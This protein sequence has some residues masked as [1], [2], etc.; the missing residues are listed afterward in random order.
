MYIYFGLKFKG[1]QA[2]LRTSIQN[3]GSWKGTFEWCYRRRVRKYRQRSPHSSSG[4][5]MSS[6]I[7]YQFFI[8]LLHQPLHDETRTNLLTLIL[9][10][11][12]G[13]ISFQPGKDVYLQESWQTI[14]FTIFLSRGPIKARAVIASDY[15]K[16]RLM[17]PIYNSRLSNDTAESWQAHDKWSLI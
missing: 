9:P 15:K 3:W 14:V 1:T 16:K 2:T 5:A 17:I 7:F 13:V 11:G 10:L 12:L 8:L 4:S 6:S